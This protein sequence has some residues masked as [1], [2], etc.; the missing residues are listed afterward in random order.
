MSKSEVFSLRTRGGYPGI[1]LVSV[2]VMTGNGGGM[3]SQATAP[4]DHRPRGGGQDWI[5]LAHRRVAVLARIG[6]SC[7]DDGTAVFRSLV[8]NFPFVETNPVVRAEASGAQSRIVEAQQL[9][10]TAVTGPVLSFATGVAPPALLLA[11]GAFWQRADQ[12][13]LTGSGLGGGQ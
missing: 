11:A 13:T 3:A 5:Q 12:A 8:P 6:A 2:L 1:Q 10:P 7:A 4:A 9:H